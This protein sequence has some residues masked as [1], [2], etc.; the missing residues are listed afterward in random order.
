MKQV[1]GIFGLFALPALSGGYASV[2]PNTTFGE[3]GLPHHASES[4]FHRDYRSKGAVLDH[5]LDGFNI[6]LQDT[7]GQGNHEVFLQSPG[8]NLQRIVEIWKVSVL[9]GYGV[10][11]SSAARIVAADRALETLVACE[12][13]LSYGSMLAGTRTRWSVDCV[14]L[15][16]ELC[17]A[18]AGDAAPAAGHAAAL[19]S[20]E[21]LAKAQG[22]MRTQVGAMKMESRRLADL[23]AGLD[24][25][26]RAVLR[27][28]LDPFQHPAL[29]EAR[30]A[31]EFGIRRGLP[32]TPPRGHPGQPSLGTS[33]QKSTK[34]GAMKALFL[35]LATLFSI[36]AVNAKSLE[37]GQDAPAFSTKDHEGKSFDL[38][39]RKGHWTV[40]YFYPK[41]G[42]PGCTKQAC[43][44][45]DNISK[46]REKGAEVY[47]V[48][49][50]DVKALGGFHK[51]HK[52][53][54]PLL[55][56]PDGKILDLY[57]TKM[58]GIAFSKRWTFILDPELRVRSIDKDVDPVLDAVK[59]ADA[60]GK[61]QAA[62]KP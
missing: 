56:D 9:N 26:D 17:R 23:D 46:I 40:L 14:L 44:F 5:G 34:V 7:R 29:T 28:R 33:C 58:L 54:F 43:A 13:K 37:V 42:T 8:G 3:D 18:W 2:A 62:T 45:R 4:F 31:A 60:L 10:E 1:L 25:P 16:A 24:G 59:V 55:A 57:G 49:S 53:N 32:E 12:S 35:S 11:F 6:H 50:D 30:C 22:L 52:L 41:A 38:S 61:F 51:E 21:L 19:M 36:S 48:S 20:D 27:S 39:S 47:G 15:N